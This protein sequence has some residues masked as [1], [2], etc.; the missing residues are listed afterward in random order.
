MS[1]P[2][3]G[4]KSLCVFCWLSSKVPPVVGGCPGQPA[5]GWEA[6]H[7]HPELPAAT[8]STPRNRAPYPARGRLQKLWGAHRRQKHRPADLQLVSDNQ[9]HCF[10]P[11]LLGGVVFVT[12]LSESIRAAITNYH[13][14]GGL[15]NKHLFVVVL[16]A[17]KSKIKELASSVSRE[18]P[19]PAPWTAVFSLCPL[20][21]ERGRQLSGV[22]FIRARIPF[23]RAP[24]L[25]PTHLP[26]VPPPK[27]I[28]LRISFQHVNFEETHTFSLGNN[29]GS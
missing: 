13:R 16:E 9:R 3:L 11:F 24:P 4:L 21:E 8:Q 5:G 26:K 10:K 22:S 18:G 7:V 25:W 19:L 29:G 27:Y 17:G 1:V 15:N 20:R 23:T 28:T 12:Q 6:R 14:L 2:S